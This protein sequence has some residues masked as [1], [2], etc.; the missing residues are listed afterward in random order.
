[1]QI[2]VAFQNLLLSNQIS[3]FLLQAI[4]LDQ[5]EPIQVRDRDMSDL[6]VDDRAHFS[7]H[8]YKFL[9][10]RQDEKFYNMAPVIVL[11]LY[12]LQFEHI[13]AKAVP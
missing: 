3:I 1:M 4:L 5:A 10:E 12:H 6:I 13:I 8:L 7:F 9:A 2:H 11:I